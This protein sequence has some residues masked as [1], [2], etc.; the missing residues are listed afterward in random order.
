[1][2]ADYLGQVIHLLLQLDKVENTY[3][4]RA[5]YTTPEEAPKAAASEHQDDHDDPDLDEA[6][7]HDSD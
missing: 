1:M 3:T 5:A 2:H 6:E 7:A 4:Y